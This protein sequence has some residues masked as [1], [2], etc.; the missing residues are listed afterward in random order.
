M[1][2]QRR[3][4]AG[5]GQS[6]LLGDLAVLLKAVGAAE[7]EQ[8]DES[9]CSGL[10]LRVKAMR[11]VRRL[12]AQLTSLIS[13]SC[14]QPGLSLDSKLTPPTELQAKLLRQALTAGLT[15]QIARRVPIGEE[16]GEDVPIGAYETLT[17]QEYVFIDASSV[18][19]CDQPDW[20]LYQEIVQMGERKTMHNVMVVECE[21]LPILSEAFCCFQPI[22]DEEPRYCNKRDVIVQSHDALFGIRQWSVGRVE[23]VMAVDDIIRYRHFARCL[24]E[25]QICPGLKPFMTHLLAS[26]GTMLRDW[27]RL[28]PRTEQLLNALIEHEITSR[29]DLLKIWKEQ[30]NYL[31][32]QLLLWLPR[33]VHE[34]MQMNWPPI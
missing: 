30:S 20:V 34:S 16:K 19:F 32:D 12:R 22:K 8:M 33:S 17:L 25:G 18:L 2:R 29:S 3:L 31:L 6:K 5:N 1:L 11:E 26:P 28:Q 15:E 14:G 23:R 24:L 4:W 9:A 13:S 7:F 27:A 21:W 10:G